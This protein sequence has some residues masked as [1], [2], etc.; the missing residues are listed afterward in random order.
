MSLTARSALTR[1]G[2]EA[3]A[4]RLAPHVVKT[5]VVEVDGDGFGLSGASLVFKLELL[6]TTNAFKYRGAVN[7]MLDLAEAGEHTG[8]VT[9]SSG[10]HGISLAEAGRRWGVRVVV[11]MGPRA[12]P[13]RRERIQSLGAEV[14]IIEDLSLAFEVAERLA[15]EEQL[16]FV[17]PY[18]GVHTLEGTASLGLEFSRQAGRLDAVVLPVG[19]GGLAAGMA[20]AMRAQQPDLAVYGVEPTG[21]PTMSVALAAG[22]PVAL[23]R[24]E[25]IAD[26]L[27]APKAAPL[28]FALCQQHLAEVLTLDDEAIEAAMRNIYAVL[29]QAIEPSAAIGTAAV[30]G[31]L[32]ERLAGRRIGLILCGANQEP[33][34][35][36][37]ML[38][39]QSLVTA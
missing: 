18:D 14:R 5:P 16:R 7:H 39:G 19:G 36:F 26:S 31:P 23:T 22:A 29:R 3:A 28:S 11:M 9:V 34:R 6:Q 21:A 27:G 17:H 37:S 30:L 10:N 24:I 4:E 20:F 25:T 12:N 15:V 1:E 33:S 13:W 32:R 38:T 2:V 35:Q 8:V